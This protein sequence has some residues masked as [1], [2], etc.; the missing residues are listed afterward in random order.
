MRRWM[1][2]ILDLRQA[3]LPP[4]RIR[5][6]I[7]AQLSR[8]GVVIVGKPSPVIDNRSDNRGVRQGEWC[9]TLE[10]RQGRDQSIIHL[11]VGDYLP[12]LRMRLLSIQIA[13][14]PAQRQAPRGDPRYPRRGL[15]AVP[16]TGEVDAE[17]RKLPKVT[18]RRPGNSPYG[19]I[20]GS[21]PY[22]GES[23]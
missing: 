13:P 3:Q 5:E 11:M 15:H 9:L 20:S 19:T 8:Q 18:P 2:W 10:D 7:G 17:T 23:R 14:V 16:D 12:R 21:A 1:I 6:L 4:E 22:A